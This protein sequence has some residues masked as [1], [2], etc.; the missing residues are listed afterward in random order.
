MLGAK[1]GVWTRMGEGSYSKMSD[2][3]SQQLLPIDTKKIF[4]SHLLSFRI[5]NTTGKDIWHAAAASLTL[6]R[7]KWPFSPPSHDLT[8]MIRNKIRSLK[9]M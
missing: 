5:H 2:D 7:P 8:P 4:L 6:T 9:Y 1:E 3:Y